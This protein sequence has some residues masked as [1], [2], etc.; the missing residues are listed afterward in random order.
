M[1]ARALVAGL[2]MLLVL[3]TAQ[4]Q[5]QAST[6]DA[7]LG[8]WYYRTS[9]PVGL[10]GELTVT[11]R[12]DRWRAEIGG[13]S[14]EGVASGGNVR[15]A[16]PEGAVF[17]GVI[18]ARGVLERAYWARREMTDDPRYSEGAAQAYAMPLDIRRDGRNRWNAAVE[19]LQDPFTLYLN[20]F[21]DSAG[22]LKAAIR[23]PEHN[24][25]GPAMLL[26]VTRNGDALRFRAPNAEEGALEARH[27][28]QSDR[29][30]MYWA[31]IERT[32]EMTRAQPEQTT[33]FYAR[34]PGEPR[35]TYRVPQDVGDGWR[36]AR[37]RDLGVDEAGLERAVHWITDIDPSARRAW[38]VHS[39]A[40]AYRGRLILDEYFYG[41]A[42]DIPHDMRSASKTFSSVILGA[43]MLDGAN[44]SPQTRLV[45]VMAPLGPFA[46]LDSR[47]ERITVAHAMTHTTGLACDDNTSDTDRPPT[48]GNEDIMQSQR[49]QPNWWKFTLDLPMTYEPGERYAYCSGG[50]SLT[51]GA[52]TMATGEWLPALFDR[53]VARPLQFGRYYWNLMSNGDGYVGGG[54]VVRT[55]DFLKIGQTYLDGGVWN[56]RRIVSEEWV[57]ESL[58]PH[59]QISPA[60]TGLEG[61]A[62]RNVYYEVPEGYAWHFITVRSGERRYQAYHGNGNGGQLLIVV[63]EFDLAVMFTAGNYR[64]GLWNLERD[65]IVGEIVIPAL[66]REPA[67]PA[68]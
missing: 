14:A 45:D 47:K 1:I 24:R 51:G 23:N 46:N 44:I 4:A 63:P 18:G 25:H 56:G 41:N 32:L 57:R 3:S 31:G 7:P 48:P 49:E 11:R 39:I 15:I 16:F 27:L 17:R 19:P 26:D 30:E 6:D 65:A 13:H 38:M 21:R 35:Y 58:L 36:I 2:C 43:A 37:A 10:E 20:I 59:V 61:D 42:Q 29:I 60:S 9:F 5:P 34:P 55:R 53:T 40:V 67:P 54:A 22:A 33:Q 28:P 12:G 62:F 66:N 68:P 8:L 64:T 50:I 52:L